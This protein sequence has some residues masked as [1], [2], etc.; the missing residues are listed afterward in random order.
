MRRWACRLAGGGLTLGLA[1]TIALGW[2]LLASLPR[3]AGEVVVP[4][5][6]APATVDRDGWAIPYVQ[7][8]SLRDG[9]FVL[10]WVHAQ[11]RLWQLELRRRIG[12]GRLAEVFGAAALPLDRYVRL[13]RLHELAAASLDA[14]SIEARDQVDAYV[15]G[16]NAFLLTDGR[17][18]PPEFWLLW[19]RPE[20]WTAVDAVVWSKLKALDLATGWPDELLRARL[21]QHL[22]H[23][24][25]DDL[26]PGYPAT[27][28]TTLGTLREAARTLDLDGL[29][30]A[31]PPAPPSGLGSNAWVVD[32]RHTTS[33]AP[34]LANDPHLGQSLPGAWYLAGLATPEARVVGATLPGLPVF[35]LGRTDRI[36][37]GM[38]NTGSD[39]QDLVIEEV[40]GDATRTPT[41]VLAPLRV[42]TTTIRCRFCPDE[43][44]T[45]RWS[46][47]GPLIS[48]LAAG[49]RTF[50]GDGRTLA[51][52]W[53]ALDP[54][55]A[56]VEAGVRLARAH[57]WPSFDAAL[58]AFADPQQNVFYADVDGRIGMVAA[59]SV[60]IR[61]NGDGTLPTPGWQ[62]GGEWMATVPH[63]ELPRAVDPPAGWLANANNALVDADFPHRLG[64]RW[65][66][67]FRMERIVDLL[68]RGPHDVASFRA[69]QQDL[70]S[71]LAAS[72]LPA[73]LEAATE[74]PDA[75]AWRDRLAAW[76]RVARPEAREP[77]VFAMW[78]D[79]LAEHLYKDELGPLF[80][81]Y[82]G[83]RAGF[84]ARALGERQIWCNDIRT[85]VVEDCPTILGRALE[86]A[87]DRLASALGS[88]GEAWM[89]ARQHPTIMMHEP[90][91]RLGPLGRFV[92]R[93]LGVGGD[94]TALAAHAY[95]PA[96]APPLFPS[97]HGP[98]LRLIVDL[99]NMAA[100]RFVAASGQ[101]GHPLSPHY[102]DL[103]RLWH[104]GEDVPMAP[105]TRPRST[106]RLVPASTAR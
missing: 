51:L 105:P 19:H 71:G 23:D 52:R 43:T 41:G 9:A 10:G 35:V 78:Y 104:R 103:T 48:D 34:L 47:N 12:Q 2:L 106:L 11:D 33:G 28:P 14:L 53:T 93:R 38:T 82:R 96:A 18:L 54:A 60:P 98:G 68:D 90:L 22:P 13:L 97:E 16:I 49:A 76:D 15:A 58:K 94:G 95:R 50:A 101:V 3:H 62:A 70:R 102:D 29:A 24:R 75:L 73:M 100:S 6:H 61:A 5:L 67:P 57:D 44:F 84:V 74:R 20:P 36:A 65:D 72:L 40:V 63:A 1:G 7:A 87:L 39:V 8:A 21:A 64:H 66:E 69:M 46:V 42:D 79:V 25:L 86:D 31:L 56:P 30:Q 81:A 88:E 77:T 59:G 32:G 45:V 4:G 37:W 55:S 91:G 85:A 83:Q 80:D 17:P 99:G 26:F 92:D 89:W 27:A